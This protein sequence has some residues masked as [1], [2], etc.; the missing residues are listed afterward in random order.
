M[1]VINTNKQIESSCKSLPD[2]TTKILFTPLLDLGLGDPVKI[3]YNFLDN[4][5]VNIMTLDELGNLIGSIEGTLLHVGC[6]IQII[7]DKL[8]NNQDSDEYL[9]VLHNLFQD[10][11]TMKLDLLDSNGRIL[12]TSSLKDYNPSAP[13]IDKMPLPNDIN[14]LKNIVIDWVN[15]RTESE[16]F[17]KYGDISNWDVSQVTNMDNLFF[18]RNLKTPKLI[19]FNDDIENWD[20]S[21][22]TSMAQMFAGATEFKGSLKSWDVSKVESM[23]AMFFRAGEFNGDIS[24]K[25]VTKDNG[26]K[27]TAWDVSKVKNMS[28]MFAAVLNIDF[29]PN[30]KSNFNSDIS[31]WNVENVENMGFMFYE[32]RKFNRDISKWN[33]S[34]VKDVGMQAMFASAKAF[35]QDIS[36]KEV[37]KVN[38]DKYT[39]WDVSQIKNMFNIFYNATNFNNGEDPG[40]STKKLN[41]TVSGVTDMRNMFNNANAF[42]QD[43]SDWNVSQVKDKSMQS[44]FAGAKE[45]NQDI[46]KKEVT[47]DNGD[48]YTAWDV[49]QLK[50]MSDMFYNATK[51]N[52]GEEPGKSTKKLNWTVSGVT[53]MKNMFNNA[54]AFNQDISNWNVSLVTNMEAMFHNANA[55]NQDISE[56]DVSNVENMQAIFAGAKEFNQDIIK[57]EVTKDNGDKYTAWDISQI[58]DMSDMFYGA[59]KFN[60]GEEPGKSTKKLNWT[61][62]GVTDMKN[63]FNNADAFNQDIS[64]WN[65]SLVTNMEAMFQNANAFNQDISKKEVTKDNGDKYTA[66]DVSN[67]ENMAKMF[68]GA[69][70]FD[71]DLSKWDV[72]NVK[73]GKTCPFENF[74]SNLRA[75]YIPHFYPFFPINKNIVS[76]PK[77]EN[78]FKGS[79]WRV[80]TGGLS[81]QQPTKRLISYGTPFPGQIIQFTGQNKPSP[82]PQPDPGDDLYKCVDGQCVAS[83]GGVAKSLCESV[84]EP[85][86]SASALEEPDETNFS[87]KGIID[88]R[89]AYVSQRKVKGCNLKAMQVCCWS[90]SYYSWG[91]Y[92]ISIAN[93]IG[94]NKAP[95]PMEIMDDNWEVKY[96]AP[97]QDE[98]IWNDYW[99]KTR[100]G[101]GLNPY[102][103][104]CGYCSDAKKNFDKTPPSNPTLTNGGLEKGGPPSYYSGTYNVDEYEYMDAYV[105]VGGTAPEVGWR[106]TLTRADEPRARLYMQQ[107]IC[108]D[109]PNNPKDDNGV[110]TICRNEKPVSNPGDTSVCKYNLNESGNLI[111]IPPGCRN[112][113][114][115]V[116]CDPDAKECGD[117]CMVT[118]RLLKCQSSKLEGTDTL[119][120]KWA[121]CEHNRCYCFGEEVRRAASLKDPY[122][123]GPAYKESL[124]LCS[125]KTTVCRKSTNMC[126]G[127]AWP[128]PF[129]TKKERDAAVAMRDNKA[130]AW[131]A[132]RKY[133]PSHTWDI[134][135]VDKVPDCDKPLVVKPET[136]DERKLNKC[137]ILNQDPGG[138][139]ARETWR[140]NCV[141]TCGLCN[142]P[143]YNPNA[144]KI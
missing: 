22:V 40:K 143:K 73:K 69:N 97:G 55:F 33:I 90:N 34:K 86:D 119:D 80:W 18:D 43:I 102:Q 82:E 17:Q 53:D 112:E 49:S 31:N 9:E 111:S 99:G 32:A 5:K 74:S 128:Y 100:C 11:D 140:K 134:P 137:H 91:G 123:T 132:F 72:K 77:G 139:K 3:Q 42:N 120:N 94:V 106:I 142:D 65:V 63:M 105:G 13:K 138:P 4:K 127:V 47:K 114:G 135:C 64:D 21:N 81:R 54:D 41:W 133:G 104:E 14:I 12:A 37:T 89:K 68:Y 1:V 122:T 26:D 30:P 61:V 36:T 45:F 78:K 98:F 70:Q 144:P 48:K 108:E 2:F 23:S 59:T 7:E 95:S 16:A 19:A 110:D 27:Y 39:A 67:V 79:T 136:P 131:E 6:T 124:K 62:S 76:N 28:L 116:V 52:N 46:S 115:G 10:N 8:E 126:Y 15:K 25:E 29:N 60:Y 66:W 129:S 35:N 113:N 75:N 20:V 130:T 87:Y 44:I 38:G 85:Q 51:F 56:W 141:K 125:S 24:T 71:R 118:Y 58:K 121:G 96:T 101:G 93:K 88:T 57:K 103:Y 84:C 109:N 117:E 83:V 50:D 107:V 92:Q